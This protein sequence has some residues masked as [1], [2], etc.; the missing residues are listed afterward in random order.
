MRNTVATPN[1]ATIAHRCAR[2]VKPH[3]SNPRAKA[4][5][6]APTFPVSS[7]PTVLAPVDTHTVSV[8]GA[9]TV[10]A[11]ANAPNAVSNEHAGTAIA[12][13][14]TAT[15]NP[16]S[17]VRSAHTVSATANALKAVATTPAATAITTVNT[18]ILAVPMLGQLHPTALLCNIIGRLLTPRV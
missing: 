4:P 10:S 2:Y 18:Q 6:D 16:R 1:A 17:S 9:H 15:A 14:N 12:T 11:T 5:I 13:A 7:S 8:R 3:S